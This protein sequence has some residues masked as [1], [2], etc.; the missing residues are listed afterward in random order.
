MP[1]HRLFAFPVDRRDVIHRKRTPTTAL[2]MAAP[3]SASLLTAQDLVVQYNEQ[4]VLDRASLSIHDGDRIGMVGRNGSGKS[5]FLRILA[6]QMEPDAG[7]VARRRGLVVGY[8]PQEFALDPNLTVV[9]NIRAGAQHLIDLIAEFESLPGN[10]GRHHDLEERINVLDGWNLDRR[11]TT[12]MSKLFCPAP[13]TAIA[14]LSGGE[15]RRVALCRA[16]VSQPDLLILDEP[17]NHLDAESIEWLVGFLEGY[18]G[19]FLVV[20]HDRYFLDRVT[21][22]IVDL[23]NEIGRAHV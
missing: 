11:I 19:A 20:T 7:T 1:R 4:V 18:P 12:A 10:S 8:L 5:T 17:T 6:G 15:K 9:E 14:Q 16:V 3:G 2:T 21:N 22:R 23:A 13:D